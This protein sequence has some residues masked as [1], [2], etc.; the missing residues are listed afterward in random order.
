MRITHVVYP[1]CIADPI[2][3]LC[4]EIVNHFPDILERIYNDDSFNNWRKDISIFKQRMEMGLYIELL[5]AGYG[6]EIDKKFKQE[7]GIPDENKP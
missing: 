3:N 6:E 5:R 2:D 1:K 4:K 7:N